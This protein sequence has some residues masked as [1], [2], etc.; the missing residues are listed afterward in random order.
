MMVVRFHLRVM[1]MEIIG[2][3]FMLTAITVIDE[4]SYRTPIQ[5]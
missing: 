2:H 1:A 5:T 3:G 4:L